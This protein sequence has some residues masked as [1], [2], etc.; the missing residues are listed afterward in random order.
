MLPSGPFK[1]KDLRDASALIPVFVL[2]NCLPIVEILPSANGDFSPQAD[3]PASRRKN[4][5]KEGFPASAADQAGESWPALLRFSRVRVGHQLL[6]PT[7]VYE[8][9]VTA[10]AAI[11]GARWPICLGL[12]K[13]LRPGQN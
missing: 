3:Q 10:A 6:H 5:K 2:S 12:K 4:G 1:T 9:S 8:R 11:A 13:R 7:T